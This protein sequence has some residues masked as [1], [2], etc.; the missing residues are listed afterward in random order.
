MF[1]ELECYLEEK[2]VDYHISNQGTFLNVSVY[3][4]SRDMWHKVVQPKLEDLCRKRIIFWE[5]SYKCY[6]CPP[7]MYSRVVSKLP[8]KNFVGGHLA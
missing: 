4:I 1:K 3:N 7:G 5:L 6:A 2:F 8:I